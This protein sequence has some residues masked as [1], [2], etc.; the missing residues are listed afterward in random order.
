[1]TAFLIKLSAMRLMT[2]D[3]GLFF[4]TFLVLVYIVLVIL[5]LASVMKNDFKGGISEKWMWLV[6]I[7]VLP[8]IGSLVYLFSGGQRKIR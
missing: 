5:A 7:L 1:V 6:L 4:W 8:F 3:Y 2:P